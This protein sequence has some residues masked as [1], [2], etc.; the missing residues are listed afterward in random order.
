MVKGPRAPAVL[1]G[2]L[3]LSTNR[4]RRPYSDPTIDML[5]I[6]IEDLF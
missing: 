1:P 6:G 5:N 4:P 3:Y 2:V